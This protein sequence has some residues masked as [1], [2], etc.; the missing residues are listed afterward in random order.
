MAGE[1]RRQGR[2]SREE[3]EMGD[4]REME[5]RTIIGRARHGPLDAS[6]AFILVCE[7]DHLRAKLEAAER[8]YKHH[9]R[10]VVDFA[11]ELGVGVNGSVEQ[12]RQALAAKD[13]A[14]SE[15][16]AQL[17]AKSVEVERLKVNVA[18]ELNARLQ[19]EGPD[20]HGARW[21]KALSAKDA[22]IEKLKRG[23]DDESLSLWLQRANAQDLENWSVHWPTYARGLRVLAAAVEAL[24]AENKRMR[25][26]VIGVANWDCGCFDSPFEN[27][28]H[29]ESCPVR[30][31]QAVLAPAPRQEEVK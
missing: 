4:P 16:T 27:P 14:L 19:W 31:A 9:R 25:G 23:P 29:Y 24:Q 21:S 10:L 11:V 2:T 20:G 26:A 8:D 13:A 6:D 3:S 17:A 7:L 18:A 22:E 15:A 5:V 1:A 28:G 12:V 30:I